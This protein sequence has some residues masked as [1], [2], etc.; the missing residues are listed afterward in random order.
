MLTEEEM[1]LLGLSGAAR[2]ESLGECVP[3][4]ELPHG[5]AV[6]QLEGEGPV[7]D[8]ELIAKMEQNPRFE[9]LQVAGLP[10]DAV[11]VRRWAGDGGIIIVSRMAGTA[12]PSGNWVDFDGDLIARPTGSSVVLRLISELGDFVLRVTAAGRVQAV[13]VVEA[14]PPTLGLDRDVPRDSELQVPLAEDIFGDFPTEEWLRTAYE[15]FAVS[16]SYSRTIAV[17]LVGRLWSPPWGQAASL[18]SGFPDLPPI[19]AARWARENGA[20]LEE[21]GR[22]AVGEARSLFVEL[23][24]LISRLPE[25]PQAREVA[26]R[27]LAD[28]RDDL[29][30][31]AWVLRS[32]G[33][34]S[35]LDSA[36]AQTDHAAIAQ[37][38]LLEAEL[39]LFDVPRFQAVARE[40]PHAWWALVGVD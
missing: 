33:R 29:A 26:L 2:T 6:A 39:D 12:F 16:V 31:I 40:E 38:T 28:E 19:R 22:E 15:E 34:A 7:S 25:A 8:L 11:R 36:L 18:M 9:D 21:V 17:G 20:A 30:S 5:L 37:T 35:D 1:K 4:E 23:E 14:A 32:A 13:R 10:I 3:S 24:E 27:R